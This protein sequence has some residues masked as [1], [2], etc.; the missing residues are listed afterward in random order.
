MYVCIF[1]QEL[2][3]NT[4]QKLL[5]T[6]ATYYFDG[7]GKAFRPMLAILM[8]RAVNC[9]LDIHNGSVFS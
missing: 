5:Q 3:R 1:F 4:N 2:S 7:Q 6:I 9:H 8:A